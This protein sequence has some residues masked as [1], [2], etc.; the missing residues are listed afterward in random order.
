MPMSAEDLEEL[1][2]LFGVAKKRPLNFAICMGK[3][4][5]DTIFVMHRIKGPDILGRQAKKD[6]DTPKVAFG[7][8]E[9]KGKKALLTC[10]SDIPAG[11]AKAT[12]KFLTGNKMALKISVLDGGGNLA[13][14]DGDPE[15]GDD[16]GGAEP[17]STA[18]GTSR[19]ETTQTG[20]SDLATTE[21]A[22][23]A[24][25]P[26]IDQALLLKRLG[27]MRD[28]IATLSPEA[29]AKLGGPFR[30]LVEFVKAAE[31][32]RAQAGA[33][34]LDT[35]IAM[36]G[37]AVSTASGN[38][39]STVP[40]TPGAE[41]AQTE[42][43]DLATETKGSE[44]DQA[45]LLKRL[46]A[47]RDKI[48]TLSPEA[49]AKLGGPFRKLVDF[50]KAEEL[51]RAQAG[52][53]KLDAAIAM[54][55]GAAATTQEQEPDPQTQ[56]LQQVAAATRA[57]VE[58][59][60][61]EKPLTQLL[62]AMDRID[63]HIKAAEVEA[64]TALI[65]KVNDIL[66]TMP[67]AGE[68]GPSNEVSGDAVDPAKGEWEKRFGALEP[69]IN[70]ALSKG[71]VEKVDDLRKLRDWATGMAIDGQFAKAVEA[72]PRIEAILATAPADGKSA[73]EAEI[74]PEVKPFAMA[75]L[76]W[77]GAR[78]TMMYEVKR[79]ESEIIAAAAED[80]LLEEAAANV[81]TLMQNVAKLDD[82]LGTKLDSIVNAN[83][84]SD[85]DRLKGEARAVIGE[86]EAELSKPFFGDVDNNSGFAS[87]AVAST[88][89]AALADI[90]RVLAR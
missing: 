15:E 75:R 54:L 14:D 2:A 63:G 29:Q 1:K 35:A 30:T 49:Q 57:R 42:D 26:E 38:P 65:K 41:V 55:A 71:L 3:K 58:Q 70:E 78:S 40:G 47:M 32:E 56:K 22:T 10:Q 73:F 50:F 85:R 74:D 4:P 44:I 21:E 52:A 36:L 62:A 87:V 20:D 69:I 33:D 46:G 51:E 43:S 8:I 17:A 64:A 27:A 81:S 18:P 53:D 68:E 7:V 88:A 25:A 77:S 37:G 23:E 28:K 9:V 24:R 6:G 76:R 84:G 90:A 67:Q 60:T 79:L 83:T 48:A 82:R 31:L 39:A 34:K 59:V 13:E 11:I 19:P 45:V 80:E 16:E 61:D 5:E 89:R 86:Y 72:L 12:K 66:K